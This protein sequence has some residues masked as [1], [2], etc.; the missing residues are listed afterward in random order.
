MTD[1]MKNRVKIKGLLSGLTPCALLV[2]VLCGCAWMWHPSPKAVKGHASVQSA[3]V[4]VPG[5]PL[6]S[7]EQENQSFDAGGF[8]PGNLFVPAPVASCAPATAVAPAFHSSYRVPLF[9]ML[10]VM[11]I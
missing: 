4:I 1:R 3:L 6:L 2:A 10:R 11:R 8:L 9:I 5:V 7:E